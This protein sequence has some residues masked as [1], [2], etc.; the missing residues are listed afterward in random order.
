VFLLSFGPALGSLPR[1]STNLDIPPVLHFWFCIYLSI[2]CFTFFPF[3][4]SHFAHIDGFLCLPSSNCS[5]S[6]LPERLPS[7]QHWWLHIP[8]LL[9]P[10]SHLLAGTTLLSTTTH[11]FSGFIFSLLEEGTDSLSRNVGKE[12]SYSVIT[13]RALELKPYSLAGSHTNSSSGKFQQ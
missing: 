3:S 12:L 5:K 13:Q 4:F 7:K 8:S 10:A 6:S 9:S 1:S 11:T 2:T